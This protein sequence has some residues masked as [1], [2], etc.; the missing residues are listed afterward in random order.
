M[1]LLLRVRALR[2]GITLSFGYQYCLSSVIY[3]WIEQSSPSYSEFLHKSGFSPDGLV[4]R[5]K[6]FCF[7]QLMVEDRQIDRERKRLTILSPVMRWYISMPV[8]ET[9]KHVVVGIFEKREFYIDRAYNRFAVEQ[10]EILP[11]P[12]WERRMNFTMLS[13][14]TVSFPEERNGKL[15]PQYLRPNDLRLSDA[16]RNNILNKYLSLY[17][18]KLQDTEFNCTLDKG[19]IEKQ[20]GYEKVSKLVVIKEG[21]EDETKVKGIS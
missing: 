17:K 16:L 12:K 1:R 20:G 21:K 9:L 7:S 6:H 10:V 13:P 11:E 4:R 19:Y 15:F 5:F 14:I 18:N 2:G 3:K 8:N